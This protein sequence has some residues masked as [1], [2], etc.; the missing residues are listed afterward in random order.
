[1]QLPRLA[2]LRIHTIPVVESVCDVAGL[3]HLKEQNI[4]PDSM[5]CAR[6]QKHTIAWLRSEVVKQSRSCL[7]AQGSSEV[8]GGYS[9]VNPS[10]D[11]ARL[12]TR[13]QD[14][15]SLRFA[16]HPRAELCRLFIV[17]VNLD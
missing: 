10:I 17:W 11:F 7:F 4:R 8:V 9:I 12:G 13:L 14:H 2:G 1:V 15:P 16:E 3:L 6:F 5:D